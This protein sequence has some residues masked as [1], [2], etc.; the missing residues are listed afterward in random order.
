MR[1]VFASLKMRPVFKAI[2]HMRVVEICVEEANGRVPVI[3]GAGSNSKRTSC[4]IAEQGR[5]NRIN[6]ALQEIV[7]LLPPGCGKGSG[8]EKG[9]SISSNALPCREVL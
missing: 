5:R 4:K 7:T 6:S 9:G 3:A 1:I 2:E 8:N